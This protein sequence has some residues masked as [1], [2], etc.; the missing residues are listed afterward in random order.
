MLHR[1]P[2]SSLR[3]VA[4]IACATSALSVLPAWTQVTL[5]GVQVALVPDS[6][7]VA[8]GSELRVRLVVLA[9]GDPFNG[10][11]AVIEYDPAALTYLPT[12]PTSL[13]EGSLMT[14]ACGVRFLNFIPS[15][16]SLSLTHVLLC[17]GVTVTGPG[18]L[19]VLRFRASETEQ[20]TT[21]SFGTAPRFYNAGIRVLPV[22]AGD[23]QIL[24]GSPTDVPPSDR[25][26]LPR[27]EAFPNPSGASF[28]FRIQGRLEGRRG[29]S[30]RDVRGRIV[31]TLEIEASDAAERLVTW[32]GRT[33]AGAAV[34]PGV[35][36]AE[37]RTRQ[38]VVSTRIVVVRS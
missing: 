7:Q 9:A 16:G 19:Y 6:P 35:Y 32:D 24:I 27:L 5:S 36:L 23:A 31:R 18:E 22:M 29:L 17:S 26:P 15:S 21:V 13:Q 34:R 28:V 4:T 30:I 38:G 10:Y 11:D 14:G 25:A 12:S 1:A 2:V 37:L 33:G 20:L 3:L 8:P